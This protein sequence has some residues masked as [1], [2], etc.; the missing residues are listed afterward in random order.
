MEPQ[1]KSITMKPVRPDNP[2]IINNISRAKMEIMSV[3]SGNPDGITFES[4]AFKTKYP[5]PNS[6]IAEALEE[7]EAEG[8]LIKNAIDHPD[9]VWK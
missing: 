8:K 4:I 9:T 3:R 7:L 1:V 5:I 2:R 6:V